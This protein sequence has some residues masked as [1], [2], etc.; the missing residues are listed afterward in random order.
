MSNYTKKELIS[1]VWLGKAVFPDFF[2]K[3]S[4]DVWNYAMTLYYKKY[5]GIW[6]DMNEQC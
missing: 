2:I 6:I 4:I 3:E 1:L 5:D